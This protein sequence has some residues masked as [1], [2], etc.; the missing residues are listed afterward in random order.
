[1]EMKLSNPAK[2]VDTE[3]KNNNEFASG[4]CSVIQNLR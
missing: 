1:M 4:I 3:S 2:N